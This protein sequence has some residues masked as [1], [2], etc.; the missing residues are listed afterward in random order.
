MYFRRGGRN[1]KP[2]FQD[3]LPDDGR[4]RGNRDHY[5]DDRFGDER[6]VES[7]P[8]QTG[9][10]GRGRRGQGRGIV[11]PCMIYFKKC[12]GYGFPPVCPVKTHILPAYNK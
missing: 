11:L 8:R 12:V 7:G 6:Y 3:F 10:G 4:R 1:R 2:Q 5:D 9:R